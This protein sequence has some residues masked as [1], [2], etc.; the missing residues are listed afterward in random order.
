MAGL[1]NTS[2]TLMCPHGGTVT[3]VS[4]NNRV[5]V[6]G[7]FAAAS[8]D[9][10]TIAGCTL[11]V[12]GSPH[13]CVMVQWVEPGKQSTVLRNPTLNEASTGLCVAGDQAVQGTVQIVVTQQEVTGR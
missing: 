7:D 12:S 13:P 5:K 4:A 9:Q 8:T 1:L 6:G 2:S 3:I 10:F 11:N